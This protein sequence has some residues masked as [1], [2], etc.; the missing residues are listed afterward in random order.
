MKYAISN[1]IYGNEPLRTQF[2]RLAKYG[3]EGIELVGEPDRYNIPEVKGLCKEFGVRVSSILGWSIWGIPGRD[4][5]SPDEHE[6]LAALQY[7]KSCVDLANKLG[8]PVLV[9][10]PGPAGRTAPSGAPQSEK[11]WL[12]GY[13]TEWELALDSLCK[14]SAYAKDQG[15]VLGLE[16]INRYETFLVY[17]VTL[18]LR[19]IEQVGSDNLKIHLDTF[20]M[21]IDEPDLVTAMHKAGNLLVNIHVSDSNREAPG[22]G[23]ID[24][25]HLMQALN[26]ISYSGFLTLE[27]VPPGSD[28]LLM[29]R[30]SKN[31]HLRDIY[32]QESILYLQELE[33]SP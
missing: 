2:M 24:F 25:M 7:G 6:R 17:N 30:M 15:V 14:L 3:Y 20:H 16:P 11:E 5:A 31:T 19:F 13:Q 29:S 28:P 8:S 10:L 27:P 12:I 26:D 4:S 18:A 22:R 1:W 23:H 32:A 9:V 33:N 21:N